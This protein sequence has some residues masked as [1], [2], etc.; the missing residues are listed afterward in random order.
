VAGSPLSLD[1]G[2]LSRQVE[3]AVSQ[4]LDQPVSA[5]FASH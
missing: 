3:T 1:I 4:G 2:T 5:Y